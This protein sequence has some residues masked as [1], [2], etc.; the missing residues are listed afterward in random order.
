[1]SSTGPLSNTGPTSST[2]AP[3]PTPDPVQP[4][5]TRRRAL[6]LL[7][8]GGLAAVVAACTS[9]GETTTTSTTTTEASTTTTT[10]A[11]STTAAAAASE[12]D[13]SVETPQETG[14]PY[15]ADGTNGPNVLTQD[16][17]VR[18]DIT[19]SFGDYSGTAEGVP[20]QIDLRVLDSGAGCA[21]L[22]GAAVYLW[23][24]DRDGNYSIY[25][26]GVTDQNYLR[27]VQVA[28]DAGRLTFTS[29]FPGCYDGRW[30]HIHFEVYET[31]AA[32][33][34]GR[35]AILTSQ[36]ALPATADEAAYAT[37]GYEDS[38]QNLSRVSLESDNVFRD[39]AE[40]QTPTVAGDAG[41]GF[42]I[43]M[44]VVV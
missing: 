20:L 9:G 33:T 19:T 18:R 17:V 7:G 37:S 4:D 23:H 35:N 31:Q 42:T 11:T 14:G 24:A 8:A 16:G 25:S 1:M 10:G 3:D 27:G 15:P 21:P 26:Q 36:I 40:A 41:S 39:G 12:A 30:P 5:T 44:D 22:G 28:D 32:A 43:T 29:I 34:S 6:T 2:A 38:V 13:C